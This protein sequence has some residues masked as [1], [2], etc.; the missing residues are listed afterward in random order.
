MVLRKSLLSSAILAATLGLTAC[1]GS[2]SNSNDNNDDNTTTPPPATNAAPTISADNASITEDKLGAAV[3]NVS[4]SDDS[5]AVSELTFTVSD[6]R[7][8]V[9]DGVLK[10]KASNALNY[11]QVTDGAVNVTVTAT[12]SDGESAEADIAVAVTDVEA[13]AGVNLYAFNNANG[14]SSVAYSGQI[15]RHAAMVQIKSLMGKLNNETV[16]AAEGQKTAAAAITEIKSFLLTNDSIIENTLGFAEGVNAEQTTLGAIS[17]SLKKVAGEGGKIAGRDGSHMHKDWLQEGTMVGWSEFGSQAKTPEGLTL[18]FVDLL[19]AQLEAFESGSTITAEH[20]GQS[21]TLN[22]LYVTP[23]GLDLAQ[24][25]QKHLNGAVAL[26]QG[27]D[28][29]L[30][31]LLIGDKSADNSALAEGK[32]YTELEHKFDEGYGYFGAAINYLEYSDDEIAG[33]GGREEFGNGYNDFDGNGEIDLNSEYNFGNSTNA[34]KR[35]RGTKGNAHP[36]DFTAQAQLA[37]IEARKLINDNVGTDVAQWATEDQERLEALR[38]QA[39]LAWEKSIAATVVHYINDTISDDDGDIFDIAS[40]DFT[41]EQFYTVAKH[42]SE[43]KGFA[44]NF[45]FNPHSPVTA[46]NFA[47]IHELM[48]DKPVLSADGVDAYKADLE[49]ARD[50]IAA[51]Y[52][53]DAENVANW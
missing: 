3:A 7:F 1:G 5:D 12:D 29:Y 24:L 49:Q 18:H 16:G 50:I 20:N 25:V 44:L 38:D 2:S 36:T 35:D 34:A 23:E 4:F 39:I 40:G 19:E 48:G 14:E 22:K 52:G 15:A 47:N 28:D 30:D 33:K 27:A 42:W 31:E 41:A 8:E 10:L 51:A 13:T 46:E 11:E 26:S 9:V 32:S 17:G 45:Q 37:F 6:N 21:V 43:M 53:F